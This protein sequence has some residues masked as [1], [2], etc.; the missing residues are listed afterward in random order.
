MLAEVLATSKNDQGLFIAFNGEE[1][2]SLQW[3][4]SDHMVGIAQIDRTKLQYGGAAT[5]SKGA[6]TPYLTIKK[7]ESWTGG[8]VT[9][10]NNSRFQN[11]AASSS[12][13]ALVAAVDAAAAADARNAT[14]HMNRKRKF[15]SAPWRRGGSPWWIRCSDSAASATGEAALRHNKHHHRRRHTQTMERGGAAAGRSS[16]SSYAHGLCTEGRT[17]EQRLW[18]SVRARGILCR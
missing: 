10:S 16:A 6:L 7:V 2:R 8:T 15:S 1:Y 9:L 12:V 3:M 13:S 17:R 4:S 18:A 14:K 5:G 11:P